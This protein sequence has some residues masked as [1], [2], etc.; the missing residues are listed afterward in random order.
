MFP[1]QDAPDVP[2]SMMEP[3][4][5]QVMRNHGQTL[6]RLAERGGLGCYEAVCALESKRLFR[7][8]YDCKDT[9]FFRARLAELVEAD[10]TVR[11]AAL[12]AENAELRADVERLRSQLRK[13][14]PAEE[15]GRLLLEL[16]QY[17]D[18]FEGPEGDADG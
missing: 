7:N 2:W 15:H 5:G 12:E 11:I 13:S 6:E 16:V 1:I 17:R 14:V 8:G 3:A 10:Q 9:A 4:R 18:A